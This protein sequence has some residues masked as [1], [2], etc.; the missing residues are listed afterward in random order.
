MG[1]LSTAPLTVTVLTFGT[2]T[3]IGMPLNAGTVFTITSIIKILQEPVRT[4]PQA[5]I[6]I[7]QATISLGRLDAFMSS[8]EMDANAVQREE[9]CDGDIAVE[10]KDGKFSWDDKDE[11]VALTVDE[12]VIKKGDHAAVVGTV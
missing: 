12:L 1:V 7:S 2:A 6:N 5:L 10:I 8:T 9:N 3:F 11:I 4:F